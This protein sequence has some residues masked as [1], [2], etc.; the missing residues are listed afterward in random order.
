M[1]DPKVRWPNGAR[2][3]VMLSFDVDGPTNWIRRYPDTWHSS[4]VFTLGSY[5]PWRGLPRVLDLLDTYAVPGTFF[6]PAW[7]AQ[8][9]PDRFFEIVAAGHEVGHHG[10]IHELYFDKSI[11][12]QQA[13]IERSQRIFED[14]A[15][16]TASGFRTPS[17]DFR[18]ETPELLRDCGFSY[19]SSM[20]GDD[21]PYRWKIK[22]ADSTLV[23]IPGHWELDD[24]AQWGYN[25]DP[26]FPRGQDRIAGKSATFDNW[27][28]EFDGYYKY[29][30]CYNIMFHPQ[31]IGKPGRMQM[32]GELLQYI[33]AHPDVWFATGQQI[34]DWWI[35]EY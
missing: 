15:G 16:V 26:P 10:Y 27:R 6:V 9:W 21:R 4:E 29:G 8:A 13:L 7:V 5:G 34:A 22:D 33:Q 12:E 28:K 14:V 11:H 32:L 20:R 2:C 24:F 18:R 1:T 31:V 3:A 23:E 19:S 25:I 30:L 17:G 35:S